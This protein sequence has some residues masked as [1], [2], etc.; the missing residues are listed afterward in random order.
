MGLTYFV[1]YW[2]EQDFEEQQDK[3]Y[4]IVFGGIILAYLVLNMARAFVTF[5]IIVKGATNLHKA[6]TEKVIRARIL[7]FDSNPVG[8]VL[9]RF[10]KDMSV[11]DLILPYIVIFATFGI[12]RTISVVA[13]VSFVNPL[14]LVIILVAVLLMYRWFRFVVN[15]INETQ[16]MD[17]I[18]RGPIHSSFTNVVN[19]L[20]TLRT[21]ERL[22]YFKKIQVDQL[23][24]SCNLTYM[25]F[26]YNRVL[27][28]NMD[29][30][31]VFFLLGVSTFTILAKGDVPVDFLSM[32]LQ[33]ITDVIVY[34]SIS[35]RMLAEIQNYLTSSQRIVRYTELDQEDPLERGTDQALSGGGESNWPSSG[36]IEF[37]SVTMKYREY[38]E[39]SLK[40]LT[41]KVQPRMKVGVVG[42]TGSGKSSIL[43]A[44]FRLVD[45]HEGSILIDGVDTKTLGLHLLRKSIAFIPQQPFLIQG[46]IRENLDPFEEMQ[47]AQLEK[48]LREVNMFDY[49]FGMKDK[50]MTLVTESNNLFSVGQKQLICL[51]RAILRDS[52]IL[53][54]DEATANVDLETDNLIQRKIKE[55]FADSTVIIIAHRLATVIDAD[56]ILV[57]ADG[58]A[59]EFDHPFKLLVTDPDKDEEITNVGGYFAGMVQSTGEETAKQLFRVAKQKYE[60]DH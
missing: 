23:E 40:E 47:D 24:K 9:T 6:M 35:F 34:F 15:A 21:F 5:F 11:L 3:F 20:V 55:S 43:Q 42:R 56:R 58:F 10:S 39:P 29:M 54:L 16:R 19:G 7:F 36:T 25:F 41:F 26:A 22:D 57:M 31:C 18:Y 27:G 1:S 33:S 37:R 51:A 60:R 13:V 46:T 48:V 12:F 8:R 44:L 38:L 32:I 14:I 53:V 50:L 52:K 4:P 30:I 28:F 49:I 17:S 2:A 45:L 59:T